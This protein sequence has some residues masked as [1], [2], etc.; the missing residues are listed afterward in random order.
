MT[1]FDTNVL[2]YAIINQDSDKQKLAEKLIEDAILKQQFAI[3]PLVLTEMVFV[4][5]KLGQLPAQ[6][7]LLLYFQKFSTPAIEKVDVAGAMKMALEL[8]L[9]KSINDL[10]HLIHA[11]R[12]GCEKLLTF[13]KG[14]SRFV[15]QSNMELVVL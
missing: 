7:D 15:S 14:F 12:S 2:V 1:F 6:K 8:G 5:A 13:D 3:S 4:L 9:G 11:E 10:V